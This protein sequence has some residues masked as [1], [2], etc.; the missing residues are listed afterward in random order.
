M[1][2]QLDDL[3]IRTKL[4]LI[5]GTTILSVVMAGFGVVQ[6]VRN[7]MLSDRLSEL[8]AITETAVSTAQALEDQVT[9]GKMS[10][11]QA[12]QIFTERLAAQK[13][14]KG[15]GYIFA[16]TMDGVAVAVPN[17]AQ[18]GTNRLD[19]PVNGSPV[20]R[21][22]R[23]AVRDQG[24]ATIYYDFP[25]PGQD[26]ASPKVSVATS[27][28]PWGIF[29]GSGSYI[30]DINAR[31]TP[32]IIGLVIAIGV[33][34]AALAAI[35]L[36]IS[37]R[38]TSPLTKLRLAMH[39]IVG[40]DHGIITPGLDR[41]DDIGEM[42]EA[43]EAFRLATI[44]KERL[45]LEASQHHERAAARLAEVEEAHRI[46]TE[47]QARVVRQ[48]AQRLQGLAEGHLDTNIE[49]FFPEAY[50]TLRMDFNQA[51]R[52]LGA[53]LS[54]IGGCSQTVADAAS[55]IARG[56]E[57]LGRRA[58][59]Q[60]ATLEETAAA[61]DQITATVTQTLTSAKEA[62]TLAAAVS[63]HA[64]GSRDV[65]RDAVDAIAAIEKSSVKISQII[66]VIDEIAFQTNLLAL[67]AGVEAARAGDAGRGFAV[68][69]QEVRALAQRSATAA[70]E[71]K[72]LIQ[73]SATGVERGVKLVGATGAALHTIVDQV[74]GVTERVQSIANSSSEQVR[75]LEEVN[76][77]IA[78]LD[79]VTQQNAQV[80]DDAATSCLSL[81]VEAERLVQLVGR[82]T[83]EEISAAGSAS[84][85][86]RPQ[87]S[88]A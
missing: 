43:V 23:D 53:A 15:Q 85:R 7:E 64:A 16:Y 46:A 14:D 29:I 25:R 6:L 56:A 73:E 34:A 40:G 49:G 39:Q 74:S 30:D 11:N 78:Q 19:V 4:A 66:G 62:A 35:T 72:V 86:D 27:F 61:H 5:V 88:A 58:E 51:V 32:I 24:Q 83:F 76:R 31:L 10:R 33:L 82:F 22:I 50:K 2:K 69:A 54:E 36:N 18:I 55:K 3:K 59:Q 77:A 38:I 57:E 20:I 63:S 80:A 65:V 1:L 13:Y 9:A 28:A 60:A 12:I 52:G 71:I 70:K 37:N 47:D 42:A 79:T 45:E 26:K 67:N 17:V 48:L 87:K 81:T 41:R 44:A 8:R 68:V 21:K 75:G 84:S